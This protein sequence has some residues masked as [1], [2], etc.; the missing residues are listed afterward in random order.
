MYSSSDLGLCCGSIANADFRTLAECAGAAGFR[1]ITLWPSHF[2]SALDSGLSV[3][4]M[5][6]IL[7]DNG[8]SVSELDPL[9]S[10]LPTRVAADDI[11]ASFAH[12]EESHFFRI[13]DA[14]GARSLNV[15]QASNDPIDRDEV[16]DALGSLCER[17]SGHGLIVSVEF[18]PW[19][20]I[21]DLATA[22]D[23]VA[24]TGR[25]DCGVN[26]D[27]WHH[28]RSGGT[29]AEL[30]SLPPSAVA[31][32]QLSDVEAEPWDDPLEETARARRLPGEGAGMSVAAIEAF[33]RAGIK[34]PITVEVFSDGL[35]EHPPKIAAAI[36]AESTRAVL[37]RVPR[38]AS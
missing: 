20:P 37:G 28:F 27:T 8:V 31:A 14:I 17:A 32:I 29:V 1:F 4:D 3:A 15:I 23:L 5:N 7:A 19:S 35:R 24:A 6:S 2:E 25:S 12:Y 26:V 18:M 22:L 34:V 33:S 10:W 21:G 30:A 38:R 9:C 13:A 36:L 16:V 11:A